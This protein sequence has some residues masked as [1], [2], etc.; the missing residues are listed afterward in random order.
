NGGDSIVRGQ[1]AE[2]FLDPSRSFSLSIN[3][4]ANLFYVDFE[5][6]LGLSENRL[7]VIGE[8]I[9]FRIPL[10]LGSPDPSPNIDEITVCSNSK[11]AGNE[12]TRAARKALQQIA[13]LYPRPSRMR[14]YVNAREDVLS[15]DGSN[16]SA[17]LYQISQTETGAQQLLDFIR[18]LPEQEF[19]GLQF[20]ETDRQDVMVRLIET[21]GA[22]QCLVDAP[23]LSDGTLCL[24][25]VGAALLSAPEEALVVIDGIDSS[26]DPSRVK[27][28]V[29]QI[30]RISERRHLRVLIVTHNPSLLDALPAKAMADV[31]CCYRDVTDGD[32]RLMRLGN[33]AR[34]RELVEHGLLGQLT[35]HRVLDRFIKDSKVPEKMSPHDSC[36]QIAG[37]LDFIRRH[38]DDLLFP[39]KDLHRMAR[40][41][42]LIVEGL[43]ESRRVSHRFEEKLMVIVVDEFRRFFD[44]RM[45]A[46][47]DSPSKAMEADLKILIEEIESI[48][49]K[50]DGSHVSLRHV[51]L[52]WSDVHE[53]IEFN[54]GTAFS[55][56]FNLRLQE[57]IDNFLN[58]KA[59]GFLNFELLAEGMKKTVFEHMLDVCEI[60]QSDLELR[61][62][63]PCDDYYQSFRVL[64]G[65]FFPFLKSADFDELFDPWFEGNVDFPNIEDRFSLL[66]NDS[67]VKLLELVGD[68]LALEHPNWIDKLRVSKRMR[69]R[70]ASVLARLILIRCDEATGEWNLGY[71]DVMTKF[72][73]ELSAFRRKYLR[74]LSKSLM[75]CF[76]R[77]FPAR[78]DQCRRAYETT[79]KLAEQLAAL[80]ARIG[81]LPPP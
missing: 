74:Q 1:P 73:D 20:I 56:D 43:S 17:V 11:Q 33:M 13:F 72:N 52:D 24:L 53:E 80:R 57:S 51:S 59:E 58:K 81:I 71:G 47:A 23:L 77:F 32:S 50:D 12:I 14:D 45:R 76:L 35:T 9:D 46:C 30:H 19:A 5:I 66:A 67:I 64:L 79:F 38:E 3:Q 18:A 65:E 55:D 62:E 37:I 75:D 68:Q 8:D 61:T 21:F 15:E 63:F 70:Y 54:S 2:L 34:F 42:D 6:R 28:I 36:R 31:V 41:L 26:F 39:P 48:S 4:W 27:L 60:S 78:R 22:Q 16:L 44:V 69:D 7:V 25:A 10:R 29:E 40:H 49:W